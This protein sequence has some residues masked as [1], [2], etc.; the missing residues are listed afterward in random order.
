MLI[1]Y[2]MWLQDKRMLRSIVLKV[3]KILQRKTSNRNSFTEAEEGEI[4]I[5]N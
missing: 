3:T 5:Q 4:K 1:V 2:S